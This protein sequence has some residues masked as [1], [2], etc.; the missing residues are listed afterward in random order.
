[1]VRK[2]IIISAL[3]RY[4]EILVLAIYL[5]SVA[6]LAPWGDYAVGDDFFYLGQ[7]RAFALGDFTKSGLIG[8]TFILQGLIGVVWGKAFGLTYLSIRILTMLISILGVLVMAKVLRLLNICGGIGYMA[9]FL[10]TFNPF[11]YSCSLNFMTENYFLLFFLLSLAS[12]LTFLKDAKGR[13]LILSAVFGGLAI[14][15]RQY[16]VVLFVA[17]LA[18]LL[19]GVKNKPHIRSVLYLVIP[20]TVFGCAGLF[21]PKSIDLVEPKSGSILL[22]FAGAGQ[23]TSK[24]FSFALFPYIGFFLLPFAVSYIAT[25]GKKAKVLVLAAS[26]PLAYL[27]YRI[28]IFSIGNLFYL[29]GYQA[30]LRVNIREG[31]FNN[32]PFKLFFALI[33]SI[34]LLVASVYLYRLVHSYFCSRK[35]SLTS[36]QFL[37]TLLLVGFYA[38]VIVTESY[39]DRYFVNFFVVLILIASLALA[40]LQIKVNKLATFICLGIGL[41]TFFLIFDYHRENKLKWALAATMTNEMGIGRYK[42]FIDNNYA[43][44]VRA[45][46]GITDPYNPVCFVQEYAKQESN[47]LND[48][49][50]YVE[51]RDFMLKYLANPQISLARDSRRASNHFD[52]TDTLL[53]EREYTS[54]MYNLVGK[55]MFVRAF[56]VRN[57]KSL[58]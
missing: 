7:T 35:K 46:S 22:F 54:P 34:S 51:S 5:I 3:L 52:Q 50:T 33:L 56:C 4:P 24:L 58:L 31:L 23:I 48:F 12:F 45:E 15:I 14:M 38:I 9:L 20:F 19:L 29:E 18:V 43:S 55:R 10:F 32:L 49:L 28:N 1:M 42:I 37:M 39:F 11:F 6:I 17:Y 16:G 13:H 26:G 27:I 41:L 40:G 2:A 8:P 25:L 30:R 57:Y 53:F 44:T 21:W 47:A 36:T